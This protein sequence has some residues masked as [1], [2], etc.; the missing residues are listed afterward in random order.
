MIILEGAGD[1]LGRRGRAAIDQHHDGRA[2][3]RVA[4]GRVHL[5]FGF[6]RASLGGHDDAAIKERVGRPTTAASSTPPG[7]LRRSSTS[8]LSAAAIALAQILE[9]RIQIVAG[10]F[11][12]LRNPHIAQA[13]LEQLRL[14]A[15][16]FDPRALQGE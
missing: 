7:L 3:Q 14:H 4:R 2:V 12:E 15:V 10:G 1:D 6:R 8:P 16:Q 11:A 9:R 13:G 5:E